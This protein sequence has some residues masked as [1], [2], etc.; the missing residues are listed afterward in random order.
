MKY[1]FS[2][3]ESSPDSDCYGLFIRIEKQTASIIFHIIEKI[4]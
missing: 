2:R 3:N 4:L 1:K